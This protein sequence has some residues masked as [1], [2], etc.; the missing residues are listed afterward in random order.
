MF[1]NFYLCTDSNAMH[2]KY[3][4]LALPSSHLELFVLCPNLKCSD[5]LLTNFLTN[6]RCK[7][8][9]D[10]FLTYSNRLKDVRIVNTREKKNNKTNFINLY[11]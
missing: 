9:F 1:T 4:C 8:L 10:F 11:L 6:K 7:V 2:A 5:A 3:I